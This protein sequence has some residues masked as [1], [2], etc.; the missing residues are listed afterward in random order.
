MT[1][2]LNSI[3][4]WAVTANPDRQ[5]AMQWAYVLTAAAPPHVDVATSRIRQAVCLDNTGRGD[6]LVAMCNSLGSNQDLQVLSALACQKLLLMSLGQQNW[7]NAASFALKLCEAMPEEAAVGLAIALLGARHTK[8]G[9]ENTPAATP[10]QAQR[11]Q[12]S[13]L[14]AEMA[15]PSWDHMQ[16]HNSSMGAGGQ[17]A[18]SETGVVHLVTHLHS[19]V[20]RLPSYTVFQGTAIASFNT[21]QV[22]LHFKVHCI[23][24]Y[25]VKSPCIPRYI[26]CQ[27]AV[28]CK[29][30]GMPTYIVW[31]TARRG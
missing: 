19:Q 9:S 2:L 29:V 22:T 12:D 26:A 31:V 20:H 25:A 24:R 14:S 5:A 16:L 28:L 13:P 27:A 7:R 15:E 3:A 8:T 1:C 23:S 21:C 10:Q 6:T 30:D 4:S 18:L 17:Q 11:L